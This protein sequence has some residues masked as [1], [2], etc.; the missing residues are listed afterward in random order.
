MSSSAS[1]AAEALITS[2]SV[3]RGHPDKLCDQVSDLVLDAFL[4]RDPRARVACETLAMDGKLVVAGE[5]RTADPTVVAEVRDGL[6]ERVRPLL[7]EIG[8][9][10]AE[11]DLDPER[12]EIEPR[13]NHQSAQI[14]AAVDAVPGLTGAGDQGIMF[15]Y[16]CDETPELLPLPWVLARSLT[17]RAPRTW[18]WRVPRCAGR[19]G[20][21]HRGVPWWTT[22][23]TPHDRRVLPART[24]GRHR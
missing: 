18:G 4:E 7:R 6:P 24:G 14:A 2:E 16:A 17:R 3:T 12:C 9:R 21:G 23:R 20:A 8:Y 22:D 15:G 13:F 1:S 10:S 5:F 19:Q 11:L